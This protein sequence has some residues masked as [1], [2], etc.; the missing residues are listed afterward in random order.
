[1]ASAIRGHLR[2]FLEAIDNRSNPIADI[3]QGHISSASCIMANNA[4]TLGRTFEFDPQ[5]HTI[6]GDDEATR[7]LRRPYRKPYIH[8]ADA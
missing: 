6:V 7:S 2:N 4:M 1:M 3:E 8:P 5:T